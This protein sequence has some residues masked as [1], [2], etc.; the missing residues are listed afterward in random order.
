VL[1]DSGFDL[2]QL[3]FR[4]INI[5][6]MGKPG[7]V[8]PYSFFPLENE[9]NNTFSGGMLFT[10]G[11]LNVGEANIDE[12]QLMPEHGRFHSL[13]A[14]EVCSGFSEEEKAIVLTGKIT[15][16]QLFTHN[17][18][19][20]RKI[21]VPVGQDTIILDDVLY[22]NTPEKVEYML[23]YHCNFGYPFLDE[24]LK[25]TLPESTNI[26]AGNEQ[27]GAEEIEKRCEFTAP[28][29]G[30][31]ERVFFHDVKGKNNRAELKAFN[32]NLKIGISL[33]WSTDTLPHLTEWKSMRSTDYVLGL[34]PSTNHVIGRKKTRAAG[35]LLSIPPFESKKMHLELKFSADK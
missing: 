3:S 35:S 16:G 31:E 26:T 27:S 20:R 19:M 23:L 14:T 9:F 8:S 32:E 24:S 11:L 21:T 6:W 34:E 25:L 30:Y 12:G 7:A 15:Q 5:S 22:N 17:L 18:E 1:P 4:G 33:E 28:V 29:D 13:S 2:G 10:C